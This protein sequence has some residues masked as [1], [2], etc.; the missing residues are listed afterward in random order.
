METEN[1]SELIA[2]PNKDQYIED[3]IKLVNVRYDGLNDKRNFMELSASLEAVRDNVGR[4]Y[5]EDSSIGS[6]DKQSNNKVFIVHGHDEAVRD[7]VE[8]FL[9]RVGLDPVILCNKSN[10]GLTI[11]EKIE[12]YTDVAFALVLYTGCDEGKLK[13]VWIK[14]ES[15]AKCCL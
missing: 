9:R 15:K 8:L 2:I 1:K 4:Y 13:T 12:E 6:T 11:I 3:T 14:T 5:A 10:G 7:R